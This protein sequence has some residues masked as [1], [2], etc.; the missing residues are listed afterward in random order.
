MA[1]RTANGYVL[2]TP[3]EKAKRFARQMKKGVIT[4][5]GEKLSATDMAW[6]AG[7]LAARQDAADC[8]NANRNNR[9]HRKR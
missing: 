8:Y 3:A 6:R 9:N 2:R 7:Y 1:Y 4:E 5:T